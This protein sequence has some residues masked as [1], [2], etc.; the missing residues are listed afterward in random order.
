MEC[1]RCGR[2]EQIEEHH[3][4]ELLRGGSDEPENKEY[5]CRPCHKYEHARRAILRALEYE[6]NR[7]QINRIKYHEHRLKVLDDLNT[8][9]ITRERGT[10]IGYW[11]DKSTRYLPC[12]IPTKEEAKLEGQINLILK[13]A[14]MVMML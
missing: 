12:R 11:I 14:Q 7:G 6:K 2:N 13:D 1:R 10:H 8:P 9:E 3:I 5:L 4:V